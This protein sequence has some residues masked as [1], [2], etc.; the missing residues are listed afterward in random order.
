MTK[1]PRDR[2]CKTTMADLALLCPNCDRAIRARRPW[3]TVDEL[4]ALIAAG[5]F[6]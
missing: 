6:D 2:T 4:K 3:L 5:P 1:Q